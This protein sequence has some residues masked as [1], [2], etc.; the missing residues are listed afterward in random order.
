M[1]RFG[2]PLAFVALIFTFLCAAVVRAA[3]V[4]S[5]VLILARD[6][7]S[8]A[9]AYSGL[10]GYGI[11]YQVVTIPQSGA[12]LPT[13]QSSDTTGNY[14]GIV[15]L[16]EVSYQYSTG[17]YSALTAAQWQQ[18]YD[19]QTAFG[20]R[21]VRID[22]YPTDEFGMYTCQRISSSATNR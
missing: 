21:M 22:V 7:A 8:A 13:L 9:S 19:Y 2:S 5:T 15:V 16:S 18:L 1:A 12:S 14:G 6:S 17:F 4:S 11:P 20:V 10:Q 3:S